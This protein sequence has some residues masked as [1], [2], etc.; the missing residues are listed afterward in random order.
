MTEDIYIVA[1]NT[2]DV[3]LDVEG[4]Y[5]LSCVSI[6]GR[7]AIACVDS[8]TDY[9]KYISDESTGTILEKKPSMTVRYT[10]TA[11]LIPTISRFMIKKKD[12]GLYYYQYEI[13]DA[14]P[15][16]KYLL[17]IKNLPAKANSVV[18]AYPSVNGPTFF[19]VVCDKLSGCGTVTANQFSINNM[20]QISGPSYVGDMSNVSFAIRGV[21]DE[22]IEFGEDLLWHFQ[23]KKVPPLKQ[24]KDKSKPDRQKNVDMRMELQYGKS[25]TA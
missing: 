11:S 9:V 19:Q 3:N 15:R 1:G 7:L 23:L 6:T 17:G 22:D 2:C 12:D 20:F 25:T 18:Q 24:G 8:S 21:Y 14:S 5:I 4:D 16:M 10:V 13:T